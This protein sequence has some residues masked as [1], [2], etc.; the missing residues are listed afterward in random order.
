MIVAPGGGN[1]QLVIEKEG[2]E[3]ADWLNSNGIAAFVLK[4]RLAKAPGSKYTLPNEVYADAARAVRMVR[5]RAQEW[6]IDPARIGF[7]GFSAG[8]EVGGQS[9]PRRDAH[10]RLRRPRIRAP[11]HPEARPRHRLARPFERVAGRPHL[12]SLIYRVVAQASACES[13]NSQ[14][15]QSTPTRKSSSPQRKIPYPAAPSKRYP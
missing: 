15:S 1:T 11:P 4:Y 13:A 9:H 8:G 10:L 6:N 12:I 7:S 5:S 2:W 14:E 3:M